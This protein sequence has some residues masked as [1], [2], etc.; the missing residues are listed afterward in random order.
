M[1]MV[2]SV[3]L[4]N[5]TLHTTARGEKSQFPKLSSGRV[6]RDLNRYLLDCSL[7]GEKGE[8]L[9]RSISVFFYIFP[10]YELITFNTNY[11]LAT[12]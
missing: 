12:F 1:C 6:F 7:S 10:Q 5:E 11:I 3:T 2:N 8:D 4:K 9:Q